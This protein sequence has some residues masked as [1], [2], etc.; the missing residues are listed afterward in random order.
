[1]PTYIICHTKIAFQH[2]KLAGRHYKKNARVSFDVVS[3]SKRNLSWN[4]I[5]CRFYYGGDQYEIKAFLKLTE[6]ESHFWNMMK[7][8]HN[9]SP[10]I[11]RF[12][13]RI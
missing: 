12:F 13:L 9:L 6:N 11:N 7:I 1:M 3:I 8:K 10:Q 4:T 5:T 2:V